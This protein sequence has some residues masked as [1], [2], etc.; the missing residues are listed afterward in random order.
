LLLF[1]CCFP[2]AAP[3][4]NSNYNYSNYKVKRQSRRRP[5][6]Q[7]RILLSRRFFLD[8]LLWVGLH[9]AR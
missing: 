7:I 8:N 3:F 5:G 1:A 6:S 4:H 9:C 2:A